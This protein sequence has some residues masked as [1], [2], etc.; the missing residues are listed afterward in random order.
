MTISLKKQTTQ[1]L[2]VLKNIIHCR[3]ASMLICFLVI[4]NIFIISNKVNNNGI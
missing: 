2:L 3:G 4:V 1:D